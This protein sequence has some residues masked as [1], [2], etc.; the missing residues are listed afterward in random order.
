MGAS[1]EMWQELLCCF[2]RALMKP[3]IR[4]VRRSSQTSAHL[5]LSR[6]NLRK[7]P[8]QQFSKDKRQFCLRIMQTVQLL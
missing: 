8:V 7:V 1:G 5:K 3:T 6:E 4:P 2:R